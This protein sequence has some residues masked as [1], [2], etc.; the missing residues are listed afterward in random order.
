MY[1]IINYYL[2]LKKSIIRYYNKII[3]LA[4][5]NKVNHYLLSSKIKTF[6]GHFI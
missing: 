2:R 4:N 5:L 1:Y 3:N 6:L